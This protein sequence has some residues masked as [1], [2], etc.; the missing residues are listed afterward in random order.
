MQPHLLL[1]EVLTQFTTVSCLKVRFPAC[2]FP[3]L[4]CCNYFTSTHEWM[5]RPQSFNSAHTILHISICKPHISSQLVAREK[6]HT[7]HTPLKHH[8]SHPPNQLTQPNPSALQQL[9]TLGY[10]R[11]LRC[12]SGQQNLGFLSSASGGMPEGTQWA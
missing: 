6:Q 8:N 7:P 11:N 12:L 4:S 5:S 9:L 10:L 2:R 1:C 3:V